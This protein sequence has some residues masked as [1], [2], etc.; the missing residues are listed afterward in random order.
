MT[1]KLI[2][3]LLAG[4]ML[5]SLAA[6][7]NNSGTPSGESSGEDTK[8]NNPVA[9]FSVRDCDRIC[10]GMSGDQ[11]VIAVKADGT[12]LCKHES[13]DSYGRE[14]EAAR[15]SLKNIAAVLDYYHFLTKDGK[16][17]EINSGK[18]TTVLSGMVGGFTAPYHTL[19]IK[20]NGTI[21][22][23]FY[24]AGEKWSQ[25]EGITDW[26]DIVSGTAGYN[27][28]VGI[29]KDGTAVGAGSNKFGQ[30]DVSNW[31]ELVY[32]SISDS[33]GD[34]KEDP[35]YVHNAFTLGVTKDGK[36]LVAGKMP[37]S[38]KNAIESL[39]DVKQIDADSISCVVL[40][41]DGTVSVI[42]TPEYYERI[43]SW[44]DI[45]AVDFNAN[46]IIGLKSDGSVVM[47]SSTSYNK[48]ALDGWLR[49]IDWKL[50]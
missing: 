39:T 2:S 30:L 21:E 14:Y 42:G 36:V 41:K 37:E 12:V 4:L 25:L 35:S 34:L 5:L 26:T 15:T 18:A 27:A 48:G 28:A 32:V 31:K 16:I 8:N 11:A 13:G 3:I 43:S 45:V 19:G 24:E 49:G 1:K 29:K 46:N 7:G 38:R 17:L 6:C 10:G 22:G 9:A 50:N 20:D 47:D 33:S 40:K 44:T 23:K